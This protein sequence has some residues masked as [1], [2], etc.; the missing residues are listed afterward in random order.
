[1]VFNLAIHK[2]HWREQI[3]IQWLESGS[4]CYRVPSPVLMQD[5]TITEGAML[6]EIAP[7]SHV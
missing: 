6:G 1:M 4:H 7:Q 5:H 3:L 2:D